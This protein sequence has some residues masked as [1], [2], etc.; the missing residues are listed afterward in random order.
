MKNFKRFAA[1]VRV[2]LLVGLYLTTLILSFIDSEHA[3]QMFK[4]CIVATVVLP[5]MMYAY[6]LMFKLLKGR[7]VE[8]SSAVL[9]EKEDESKDS[10][11][12]NN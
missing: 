9:D 6:L 1:L 7:G 3:H 8:E 11:D 12:S 10:N 5:I 4:G 2:I